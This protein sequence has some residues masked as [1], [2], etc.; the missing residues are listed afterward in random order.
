MPPTGPN[1]AKGLSYA[2]DRFMTAIRS[3]AAGAVASRG[4]RRIT[5]GSGFVVAAASSA[6][7][8]LPCRYFPSF[9]RTI[10]F[11][12]A[13]SH[14]SS[15]QWNTVGGKRKRRSLTTPIGCLIR[16]S[17]GLDGSQLAVTFLNQTVARVAHW[18]RPSYPPQGEADAAL[19]PLRQ[20]TI[21]TVTI[22]KLES[23]RQQGA[24]RVCAISRTSTEHRQS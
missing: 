2:N 1:T 22:H 18:L 23:L 4:M 7:G 5:T 19:A 12:R 6:V 13:T 24:K 16:W 3:A 11:W 14:S 9:T 21:Q 20:I 15:A 8:L 17:S 10:V